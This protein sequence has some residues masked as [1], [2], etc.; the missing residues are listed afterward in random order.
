M[1]D[2]KQRFIEKWGVFKNK[3]VRARKRDSFKG[4]AANNSIKDYQSQDVYIWN[5]S[6]VNNDNKT[7][8]NRYNSQSCQFLV[9][10]FIANSSST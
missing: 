8:G 5:L 4:A 2:A 3:Q 6:G 10:F 7:N 9:T 1:C